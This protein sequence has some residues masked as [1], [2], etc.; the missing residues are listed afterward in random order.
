[1]ILTLWLA[2][3]LKWGLASCQET[4]TAREEGEV[5]VTG[6]V[7]MRVYAAAFHFLILEHF[8]PAF[9][10][11]LTLPASGTSSFPAD[12]ICIAVPGNGPVVL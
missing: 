9:W 5:G 11:V 1:M 10:R 3:I 2:C 12:A 8:I 7:T 4:A 6:E